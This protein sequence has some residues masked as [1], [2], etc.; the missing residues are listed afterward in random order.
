MKAIGTQ[1][2]SETTLLLLKQLYSIGGT[3]LKLTPILVV[4]LT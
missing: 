2:C 3:E 4:T 1:C